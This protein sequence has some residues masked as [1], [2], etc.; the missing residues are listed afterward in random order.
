MNSKI[1]LVT[2]ASSGIGEATALKLLAQGYTVYAAARRVERMRS[3]A[4]AGV[5][6]LAMDVTDDAVIWDPLCPPI[7][8]VWRRRGARGEQ[9]SAFTSICCDSPSPEQF[10]AN[11][12]PLD[13][14]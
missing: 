11:T 4:D 3:Q 12:G 2:G 13:H 1:A 14:I 6:V 5:H 9:R 7:V 10:R 8:A